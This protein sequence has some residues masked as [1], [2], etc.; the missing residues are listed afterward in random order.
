MQAAV[1]VALA[2]QAPYAVSAEQA[3]VE[4]AGVLIPL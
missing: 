1:A 4:T 2:A 3:V